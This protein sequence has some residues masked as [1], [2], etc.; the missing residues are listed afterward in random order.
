MSVLTGLPEIGATATEKR[1]VNKLARPIF[2]GMA[3][4]QRW[5]PS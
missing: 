4:Y 5:L 1:I 2:C 3:P